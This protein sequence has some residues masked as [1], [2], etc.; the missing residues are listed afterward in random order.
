MEK[1]TTLRTLLFLT[2]LAFV[3]LAV[4]PAAAAGATGDDGAAAGEQGAD[5][6]TIDST[7]QVELAGSDANTLSTTQT[8]Q[9]D[10]TTQAILDAIPDEVLAELPEGFVEDV[11]GNFGGQ[12]SDDIVA[13]LDALDNIPEDLLT[14]VLLDV[15]D[16]I[17]DEI[18]ENPNRLIENPPD[19]IP[20]VLCR[21]ADM[22]EKAD[23]GGRENWGPTDVNAQIGNQNLTVALNELGTTTVFKYPNPSYADQVKYHAM[24]RREPYYGTDPNAGTFLGLVY[25]TGSGETHMNWLR[26]WGPASTRDVDFP[27]HVDQDWASDL[28]DTL[29]TEY[30]NE[31]L[32]LTVEVVDAVPVD[33]DT[34]VRDIQI[35]ATDDS[36]VTDVEVVSYANFNPVNE[37][38]AL[39]P[40][41]DWCDED[42]NDAEVTYDEDADAIVYEK[43]PYNS[44]LPEEMLVRAGPEFSVATAMAFDGQSSQHQVAG[45]AY[46]TN[47]TDDPFA[48]LS[49]GTVD[50]P[51]ADNHT[52]Q[53][54]TALTRDIDFEDGQGQAR[55]YFGAASADEPGLEVGD[56]AVAAIDASRSTSL[57]TIVDEKAEWFDQYVGDAPLPQEAP[58]NVTAL[59]KRALVSL[60]QVW[61][62]NTENEHGLSGNIVAGVATQ[63]PYMADWIRDGAYFNYALDRYFGQN[64]SGLNDWVT[65][66][67]RWYKSLQQNPNGECP[68]HCHDNMQYYDLGLGIIPNSTALRSIAADQIPFMSTTHQG[69]WAMNYYADGLPA[70]PLGGE[71]DETAYGA[72]TFWDHYAVTE[73]ETYLQNIY[74]AIELVGDRLTED[75]VDEETGLQ[76]ARP[77]DDN[78]EYTQGVVGGASSYAGLDA[79]TK[80]AAEMYHI[81]GEESYA[82]DA[83][84]YAQRRDELNQA[85]HEHYWTPAN[86]TFS[87]LGF[88]GGGR[89]GGNARAVMPAFLHPLDHPRMQSHLESMWVKVNESFSGQSDAGQYEAKHLIGLGI[90]NRIDEDTPVGMDKVKEGVEWLADEAARA[91]TTHVLGEAW[92]RENYADGEVDAAVSQPH[93]WQQTLTYMAALTAWGN[94]SVAEEDRV[95]YDA[96]EEWRTHDA[97]VADLALPDRVTPGDA[98]ETTATIRNDAPVERSYHVTYELQGPGGETYDGTATDVGPIAP[99]ESQSVALT[100]STADAPT[101]DYD[102]TVSV[103]KAALTDENGEPDAM[104]VVE[105]PTGLANPAYRSVTLDTEALADAVSVQQQTPATFVVDSLDPESGAIGDGE[106]VDVSADISNTGESEGTTTVELRLDGEAVDEETVTLGGGESQTVTFADVGGLDVGE[107]AHAVA[108]LV[109]GTVVD[110]LAGTLTVSEGTGNG[111]ET[112]DETGDEADGDGAGFGVA[113]AALALLGAALLAVRRRA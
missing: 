2:V 54:S 11:L 24:D 26:D 25:E 74:P 76:C 48:L 32:G 81:T 40:T 43:P 5:E 110:E 71:I 28:S 63:A 42:E 37:K 73:N 67:N 44:T 46:R 34:H 101:G 47:S 106:T 104:A 90:A 17:P 77:E 7:A 56:E 3:A 98:V 100:W 91:E 95:G 102:V 94:E 38:D 39:V 18:L 87:G 72:W 103:W 20:A 31:S 105:N 10:N 4:A 22:E 45:D 13:E 70:G 55:V 30:T 53:V 57:E 108:V 35:R 78:P 14:S 50:L 86:E 8:N 12:L 33:T 112:D 83:L 52:G 113:V 65:R 93:I 85:M 84:A 68:G 29:V 79:A 88:Y 66:H 6:V 75:C 51:G 61:D 96:Y 89:T 36:P 69:S 64:G 23:P 62:P 19:E 82:E 27:E 92:L 58:E 1:G 21:A 60:V 107:Y 9:T 16:N 59:S 111:N 49:N 41:K 15:V 80:A 97:A 109:D 99:G